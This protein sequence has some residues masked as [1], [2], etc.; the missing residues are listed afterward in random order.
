MDFA[1]SKFAC[2][3]IVTL[4]VFA[5]AHPAAAA[6]GPIGRLLEPEG[7]IEYSRDGSRWKRV[8]RTKYVFAGYKVRTG[9]DGR[10]TFVNQLSGLSRVIGP[11]SSV[12]VSSDGLAF[13]KG[14]QTDPFTNEATV[15][16]GIANKFAKAQRYPLLRR[17]AIKCSNEVKTARSVSLS[18]SHPDLVWNIACPGTT[19]RLTIDGKIVELGGL[20]EADMVRFKVSGVSEGAHTYKLETINDGMVVYS[21]SR[22]SRFHWLSQAQE[23]E[24]KKT[25]ADYDDDVF[26]QAGILESVGLLVAVMDSYS[27]YFLEEFD[28][29]DMRPLLVRSYSRLGLMELQKKEAK[30]FRDFP[31]SSTP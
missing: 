1:R 28:D 26:A 21:P 22:D 5:V 19:Y 18:S 9:G 27:R 10:G 17:P 24:I 30:I 25:L 8:T 3:G 14:A 23:T 7:D 6:S 4:L 2:F 11:D 16:D 15:F 20:A 29:N 31:N 13:T 12:E